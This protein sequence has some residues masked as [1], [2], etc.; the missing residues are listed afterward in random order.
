MRLRKFILNTWFLKLRDQACFLMYRILKKRRYGTAWKIPKCRQSFPHLWGSKQVKLVGCFY[1]SGFGFTD[2]ILEGVTFQKTG[3][4]KARVVISFCWIMKSQ[5]NES[6]TFP[7]ATILLYSGKSTVRRISVVVSKFCSK[8]EVNFSQCKQWRHKR[9]WST[10]V[11]QSP[12]L[13][14]ARCGPGYREIR[15]T[16]GNPCYS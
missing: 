3:I 16:E 8:R 10:V 2:R 13:Y 15:I 6:C 5:N 4:L 12:G 11:P 7:F 1:S 14:G 9:A